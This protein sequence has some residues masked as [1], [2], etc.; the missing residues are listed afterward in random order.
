M[1]EFLCGWVGVVS[2]LQAEALVLQPATYETC[3]AHKKRNKIASDIKLVFCSSTLHLYLENFTAAVT[4]DVT[5][6]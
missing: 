3:S 5:F 4:E 6:I 2:A 1:L